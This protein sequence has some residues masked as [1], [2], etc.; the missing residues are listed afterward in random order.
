MASPDEIKAKW[1]ADK[2]E[3]FER[4]EADFWS[5]VEQL[6]TAKAGANLNLS[7]RISN[8]SYQSGRFN[9]DVEYS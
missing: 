1:P 5:R 2:R 9:A 7:V 8:G 4:L 3:A 6:A